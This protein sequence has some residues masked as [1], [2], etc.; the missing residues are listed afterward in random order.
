MLLC[1]CCF[2]M[3]MCCRPLSWVLSSLRWWW[4]CYAIKLF[5]R[6]LSLAPLF[7]QH[8]I[9][10]WS[11]FMFIAVDDF[12]SPFFAACEWCGIRS[13]APTHSHTYIHRETRRQYIDIHNLSSSY[14]LWWWRNKKNTAP[15]E[16]IKIVK[17]KRINVCKSFS[18]L[19]DVEHSVCHGGAF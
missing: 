1:V 7:F 17:S 9:L 6:N 8:N 3:R 10:F 5:P 4:Y 2:G 15:N 16:F 12:N 11:F 13:V 19:Y 14:A 18:I